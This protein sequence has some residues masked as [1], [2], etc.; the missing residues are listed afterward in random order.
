MYSTFGVVVLV[1][2]LVGLVWCFGLVGLVWQDWYY[3]FGFIDL[4]WKVGFSRFSLEV[5]FGFIGWVR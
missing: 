1:G 4:V 3:R 5:R 2:R